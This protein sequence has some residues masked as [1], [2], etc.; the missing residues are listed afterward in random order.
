MKRH[1]WLALLLCMGLMLSLAACGG[2]SGAGSPDGSGGPEDGPGFSG[3]TPENQENVMGPSGAESTL[4]PAGTQ[5]GDDDIIHAEDLKEQGMFFELYLLGSDTWV[6]D[7]P[8]GPVCMPIEMRNERDWTGETFYALSYVLYSSQEFRGLTLIDK[9]T[10]ED[11][12]FGRDT[13]CAE[14][15]AGGTYRNGDDKVCHYSISVLVSTKPY[16]LDDV[17]VEVS[18]MLDDGEYTDIRLTPKGT[19]EDI[20]STMDDMDYT[21]IVKIGDSYYHFTDLG[22]IGMDDQGDYRYVEYLCLNHPIS[23]AE[24]EIGMTLDNAVVLDR[25]KETPIQLPPGTALALNET[26]LHDLKHQMKLRV[27]VTDPTLFDG[28]AEDVLEDIRCIIPACD[29]FLRF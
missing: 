27:Q 14:E 15:G 19:V 4:D 26:H 29:I 2:K 6:S 17:Y 3:G 25:D 12:V 8:T 24:N 5:S 28:D 13:R 1:R 11:L 21:Q 9:E 10:G 7:S 22:S 16:S 18:A 23:Y 20:P